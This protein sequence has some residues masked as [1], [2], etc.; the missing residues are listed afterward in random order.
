MRDSVDRR[1]PSE[2]R[3][4]IGGVDSCKHAERGIVVPHCHQ[5]FILYTSTRQ[6]QEATRDE[7]ISTNSSLLQEV[8]HRQ[9]TGMRG[10]HGLLQDDHRHGRLW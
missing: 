9:R 2:G 1:K 7:A 5:P 4:M 3:S 10:Q 8:Y 6:R